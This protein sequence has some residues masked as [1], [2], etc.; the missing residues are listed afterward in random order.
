MK[1][2]SH[3][4]YF[5]FRVQWFFCFFFFFLCVVFF[6]IDMKS[7]IKFCSC[8]QNEALRLV[9]GNY[10]LEGFVFVLN[11]M[12]LYE[13]ENCNF[14]FI[15]IITFSNGFLMK[16]FYRFFMEIYFVC[17]FAIDLFISLLL[18]CMVCYDLWELW[19]N[20]LNKW[21]VFCFFFVLRI[22]TNTTKYY[23]FG[24]HWKLHNFFIW[25]L[26]QFFE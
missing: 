6:I 3:H 12:Q 14:M 22:I 4:Y 21:K 23:R 7:R 19:P 8:D 11:W 26:F 2:L 10:R 15:S 24:C 18:I 9:N 5:R 13:W 1:T 25:N 20:H 16:F 17:N